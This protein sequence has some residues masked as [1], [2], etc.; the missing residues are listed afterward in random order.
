LAKE[1]SFSNFLK[2]KFNTSKRFG[3]EG[4]ESFISGLMALVDE[5]GA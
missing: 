5:A 4:L 3:I 2:N 1:Y